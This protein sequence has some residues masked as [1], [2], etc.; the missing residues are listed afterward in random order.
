MNEIHAHVTAS[1]VSLSPQGGN[2]WWLDVRWTIVNDGETTLYVIVTP[3][4]PY[5][6]RTP[7]VLD[8][9][10]GELPANISPFTPRPIAFRTIPAGAS[11]DL[12]EQYALP[13]WDF[14]SRTVVGRYGVNT[15]PPGPDWERTL[16]WR[17]I[18]E[19]QHPIDSE[20]I[21]L[22]A[23]TRMKPGGT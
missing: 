2:G 20:G 7:L 12:V 23:P 10:I 4:G 22:Q 17:L 21:L 1:E 14:T 3:P 6:D 9:T 13:L 8:H 16:P 11:L 18:M 19:W 5:E 15:E